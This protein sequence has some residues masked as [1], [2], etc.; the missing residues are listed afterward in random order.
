MRHEAECWM[1][2]LPV[3][4]LLFALFLVTTPLPLASATD[5]PAAD[6]SPPP[7]ETLTHEQAHVL[8]ARLSDAQVREL[9][10]QYL[11][12]HA[13][14][15]GSAAAGADAVSLVVDRAQ[16]IRYRLGEMVAGL[17]DV[18][19]AALF[20]ID[21]LTA[22]RDPRRIL[23]MTVGLAVILAA[24][25]CGEYA[26][27][28]LV[29]PVGGRVTQISSS[30]DF[31]KL[32]L[33]AA[34]ALVDFL[35]L[36]VFA[37]VGILV[38]FVVHPDEDFTR[39][40][41]WA[42]FLAFLAVRA[43]AVVLRALLA[44]RRPDLRLPRLQDASARRLYRWLVGLGGLTGAVV[45]FGWLVNRAGLPEPLTVAL[46]TILQWLLLGT[47]IAFVWLR[48]RDISA[49]LGSPSGKQARAGYFAGKEHVLFTCALIGI[50]LF[51][52]VSRLLT[53][54]GQ[55]SRILPT[56]ALLVA[57]PVLDGRRTPHRAAP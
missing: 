31:G 16:T 9:L 50:G 52:M 18:P 20:V 48:R 5:Q 54:E 57:W 14:E 13:P 35:A 45:A 24:A 27:R 4:R 29:G 32:G 34:R 8:I 30:Q 47:L 15:P 41:F 2:K 23:D 43:V 1:P 40:A 26:F 11:D 3:P 22:N 53:G 44:P 21:Q 51:A 46:G 33:L 42:A 56:L 10:L 6:A 25:A 36:A 38:F 17:P 55:A 19:Y 49:L 28:R 7:L 37:L 39:A 12:R